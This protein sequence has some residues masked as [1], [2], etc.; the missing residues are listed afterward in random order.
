MGA[1]GGIDVGRKWVRCK[2]FSALRACYSTLDALKKP[3]S[4]R[5]KRGFPAGIGLTLGFGFI[6][7]F[8]QNARPL[9]GGHHCPCFHCQRKANSETTPQTD[10]GARAGARTGRGKGRRPRSEQSERRRQQRK[11]RGKERAMHATTAP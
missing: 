3:Y 11:R 9:A 4:A 6:A 5:K 8:R 10:P 1:A 2:T 7:W